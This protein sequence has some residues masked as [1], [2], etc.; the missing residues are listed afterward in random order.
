MGKNKI[1]FLHTNR[2]KGIGGS[3][4]GKIMQGDWYNLWL[5][6]KQ[7][8]EPDD[9]S[10]ILPVQIGTVTEELNLKWLE[11]TIGVDVTPYPEAYIKKDFM[12]AHYDGWVE[13]DNALVECKHTNHFN[14][15]DIIIKR[16]YAQVQH[17]LMVGN[18]NF[19]YVCAIFGN[20]RCDYRKVNN[21]LD[22]QDNI[23]KHEKLFW[24]CVVNNI[25]PQ[26]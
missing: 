9:L 21:D 15:M 4:A 8:I 18:F 2:H 16:Y 19:A 22:Y 14:S 24:D 10:D 13:T 25:E 1:E 5:L 20:N 6:K 11:K 3:D 23:Y 17:Y 12:I 7:L 26:Q